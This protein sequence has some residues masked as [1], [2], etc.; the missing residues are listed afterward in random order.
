VFVGEQRG[1]D[2]AAQMRKHDDRADFLTAIDLP[3]GG[4]AAA[5]RKR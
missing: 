4:L 2:V 5:R 3:Q 1:L